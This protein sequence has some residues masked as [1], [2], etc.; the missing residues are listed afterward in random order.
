VRIREKATGRGAGS[1]CGR[2]SIPSE[3]PA[4]SV[5]TDGRASFK[6][7]Q[8]RPAHVYA[9]FNSLVS[10]AIC[11]IARSLISLISPTRRFVELT[12][13]VGEFIGERDDAIAFW[14]ISLQKLASAKSSR[15][16]NGCVF[17]IPITLPRC[18]LM[19][20]IGKMRSEPFDA[21]C[22]RLLLRLA[23]F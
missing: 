6:P 22:A 17:K 5:Y 2:T 14:G 8:S 15:L 20:W 10:F 16:G 21:S 4:G 9:F 11:A 18:S 19:S 1:R 13:R 12:F 7:C 23:W 3:L